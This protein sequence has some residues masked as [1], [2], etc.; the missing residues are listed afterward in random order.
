MDLFTSCR[1]GQWKKTLVARGH[2]QEGGAPSVCSTQQPTCVCV[3]AR[4]LIV[5]V[6]HKDGVWMKIKFFYCEKYGPQN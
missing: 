1:E 2:L 6:D 5:A 3:C 4:A